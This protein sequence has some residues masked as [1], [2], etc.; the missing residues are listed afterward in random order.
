ML[1]FTV[2]GADSSWQLAET[3]KL[4]E[5]ISA[6]ATAYTSSLDVLAIGTEGG[7][8]YLYSLDLRDGKSH[9]TLLCRLEPR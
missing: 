2:E 6:V 3:I 1:S 7:S 8:I 9:A 4:D 5:G